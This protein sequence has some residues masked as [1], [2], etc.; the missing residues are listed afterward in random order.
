VSATDNR[1]I[2]RVAADWLAQRDGG[3]WTIDD[4][5]RL[6][7]WLSAS[8]AHRVAFLR[9]EAAWEESGR[10]KA[11]AAGRDVAGPPVRAFWP[12][13]TEAVRDTDDTE[14]DPTDAHWQAVRHRAGRTRAPRSRWRFLATAAVLVLALGTATLVGW[15]QVSSVAAPIEYATAVGRLDTVRLSDGSHATLSS[16]SRISLAMSPGERH[17]DLLGGEAF[18]E[19]AKDKAR[20]FVI[21]ADGR[22]AIAVGTRFSV[23]RD[24]EALRVVVTEGVVRLEAPAQPGRIGAEPVLL[25]AGSVAVAT[26]SGVTV[27]RGTLAEAERA[28]EW[29]GGRLYFDD[30]P[31]SVAAE[32]FNRYN[33]QKLVMG[34]ADVAALRIGGNFRWSNP[35]GFVRLLEQ[36]F[37]VRAETRGTLIVL[38]DR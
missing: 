24:G 28:L 16:D 32:E 27:H 22:R 30:T 12:A 3:R 36:G 9:L 10:L 34:D 13:P 17:I 35:E 21:A 19:V 26:R 29:R 37:G 25:P 8:T 4:D 23:R 14:I 11:L 18:F 7:A 1:Q 5:A 2:E 31:L 38:H 6:A 20:P 33:T 15:R